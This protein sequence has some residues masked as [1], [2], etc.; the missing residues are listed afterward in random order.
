MTNTEARF[1]KSLRP[2]KPE[3]SLGRTAQDGHLDS[4]TA[5]ELWTSAQYTHFGFVVLELGQEVQL[6]A[7]GKGLILSFTVFR[8]PLP[9][10]VVV[11][12][13]VV[14]V[15]VSETE[16]ELLQLILTICVQWG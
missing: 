5:P 12:V 1:N 9:A 7:A 14:V 4:H 10:T 16:S 3:G 6:K 13:V 8:W 2:R 11:V 15:S